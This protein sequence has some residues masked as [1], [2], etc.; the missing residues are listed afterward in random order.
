MSGNFSAFSKFGGMK[1]LIDGFSH[2][3]LIVA[4]AD[5]SNPAAL[6]VLTATK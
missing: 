3:F 1:R 2:S 6:L 5:I 4:S